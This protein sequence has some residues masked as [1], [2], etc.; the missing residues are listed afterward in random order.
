MVHPQI[1]GTLCASAVG[2]SRPAGIGSEQDFCVVSAGFSYKAGSASGSVGYQEETA[3][4]LLAGQLSGVFQ[5]YPA[6]SAI[7]CRN[8]RE[9]GGIS[10]TLPA[11]TS[12]G[13][14]SLNDQNPVRIGF[15]VRRLTPLEAERLMGFPDYW[16]E[17][18]DAGDLISDTKRYQML[19]N[20]VA[21]PCVAYIMQGIQ[22]ILSESG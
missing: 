21:V 11:K 6:V 17:C 19:G 14:Y 12:S 22:R 10:G 2:L 4:T 5:T 1:A 15:C 9:T 20:S 8:H 18:D 7:D 13:G 3:P 16:T